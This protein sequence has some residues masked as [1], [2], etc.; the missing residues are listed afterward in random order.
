VR[1]PQW[2]RELDRNVG[3]ESRENLLTHGVER[4]SHQAQKVVRPVALG[5]VGNFERYGWGA[6]NVHLH[7]GA[8]FDFERVEGKV[9]YCVALIVTLGVPPSFLH[10]PET[11]PIASVENEYRE[12]PCMLKSLSRK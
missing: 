1:R 5:N 6:V 11:L 9:R 10:S 4:N 2:L 3:F 12:G 8:R 7:F